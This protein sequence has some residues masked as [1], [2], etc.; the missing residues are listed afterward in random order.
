MCLAD[1]LALAGLEAL[2][3]GLPELAAACYRLE[4][5]ARAWSC[6]GQ[7]SCSAAAQQ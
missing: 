2:L 6:Q 7:S 5:A 1:Q 4:A 3:A